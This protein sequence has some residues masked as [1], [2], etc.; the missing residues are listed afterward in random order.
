MEGPKR[1]GGNRLVVR[2]ERTEPSEVKCKLVIYSLSSQKASGAAA[3]RV[4]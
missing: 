1:E 4:E 3:R 2:S